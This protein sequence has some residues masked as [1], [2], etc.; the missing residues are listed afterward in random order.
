MENKKFRIYWFIS[1]AGVLAAS[2]YPLYMG[3]RV[4]C[5]MI[6]SGSVDKANYPKYIIPYTP[7]AVAVI[8]GVALLPLFVKL[9]G[10][11]GVF[12][13]SSAGLCSFFWLEYLLERNVVVSSVETVFYPSGSAKLADWQMYMCAV[14]PADQFG[15]ETTTAIRSETPVEIL[16]G[17]YNPAFKLH[18]YVISAVIILSVLNCLY[19]FANIILSGSR[20]K[21]R[22]LILQSV[23]AA[24]FLG[25]CILACFTA[26]WRDGKLLVSP[27]SAALMS[28]FFIMLG[29]TFGLAVGSFLLEKKKAPA[30]LIPAGVASAMTL[31]MY[32]GET[33]LLNGNL[34][35]FGEGFFFSGIPGIVLAPVDILVII[36]SGGA[37][38][39]LMLLSLKRTQASSEED[40]I[41]PEEPS[42]SD[43]GFFSANCKAAFINILGVTLSLAVLAVCLLFIPA[44][45]SGS[46]EPEV[47]I[48]ITP[49]ASPDDLDDSE[50]ITL[51]TVDD[52]YGLDASNGLDVIVWQM[53]SG[54]YSFGLLKHSNT[55]RGW[56]SRELMSLSNAPVT[57]QKM[58]EI[59]STYD[60]PQDK[61]YIVPWQNPLSS[62]MGDI[63]LY[64][65]GEDHD[66]VVESYI[67]NIRE[68][69]FG[70][71]D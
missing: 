66:A 46:S 33:I 31:I 54:G 47:D 6:E 42:K 62:Y 7:V 71:Q 59:L 58:R 11:F 26:F 32:V 15:V 38:A 4:I 40:S 5:D 64:K 3:I 2:F 19:G 8:A 52:Y 25:L 35:R 20:K 68:M 34:Y 30:L 12:A 9:F 69:L 43:N 53:G 28:L 10:R 61:I 63:W 45:G 14:N 51:L 23:S 67:A 65:E 41:S 48:H 56:L 27:L 18:F 60:I 29:V 22:S 13:G 70:Q 55:A 49:S 44:P 50:P 24:V 16:A 39:L 21:L 1:L 17:E 37:A 57:A 36:S